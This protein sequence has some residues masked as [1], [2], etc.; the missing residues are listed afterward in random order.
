MRVIQLTQGQHTVVDDDVYEW[1]S[2]IKWYARKGRY[3]FYAA[4]N[5]RLP[6][7]KRTTQWL[8]REILKALPEVEVDHADGD[9]LHN[10]RENLRLCSLAENL[11]N[12]RKDRNNTSGHIGVGVHYG[13]WR[14]RISVSGVQKH[15]GYF[16]TAIEAANARDAAA[17]ESHGAFAR[18]NFP[19]GAPCV[20]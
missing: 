10:L 14:A 15:L 9:G 6:N 4:R 11:R 3:T 19:L 7:G 17:I 13:K 2:N 12:R 20:S 5:I 8:H 1:A 16:E 18:L